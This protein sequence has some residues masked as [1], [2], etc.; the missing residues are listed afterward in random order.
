MLHWYLQKIHYES[1]SFTIQI[2]YCI[3]KLAVY[4]FVGT[5][6]ASGR[7]LIGVYVMCS[8]RERLKVFSA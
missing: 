5:D 1:C 4:L 2:N 3:L 8:R 6:A 7:L